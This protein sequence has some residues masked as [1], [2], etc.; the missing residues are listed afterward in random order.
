MIVVAVIG[1]LAV[2][3][4]PAFMASRIRSQNAAFMNDLRL[5]SHEFEMFSMAEGK[6]N[7]PPDAPV[8][9]APAGFTGSGIRHFSW[10]ELTPIGGSWK[11]DRAASRADKVYGCYGGISVVDPGRT[12]DQ[13]QDIDS[14]IDNGDITTGRFRERAGGYIYV[15]EE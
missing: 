3:A 6:G 10:S 13:M 2:L 12:T 15:V 9:T 7:Y 8:A 11:W 1:T 14:I 4:M 5:L